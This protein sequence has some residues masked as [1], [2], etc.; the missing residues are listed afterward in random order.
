M[1][2]LESVL[3]SNLITLLLT[4]YKNKIRITRLG[5]LESSLG[6]QSLRHDIKLVPTFPPGRKCDFT[7]CYKILLNHNNPHFVKYV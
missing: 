3:T 6:E 1:E 2:A 4:E 5:C 7:E